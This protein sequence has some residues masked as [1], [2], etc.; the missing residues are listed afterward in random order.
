MAGP[1]RPQDRVA[2]DTL[3]QTEKTILALGPLGGLS[4]KAAVKG[5]RIK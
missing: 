3:A 4:V 1:K 5:R 2:L